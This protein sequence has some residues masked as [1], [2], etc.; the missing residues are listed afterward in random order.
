MRRILPLCAVLAAACG[1]EEPPPIAAP[2]MGPSPPVAKPRACDPELPAEACK[3][4]PG[5]HRC[6]A[7]EKAH[8]GA[9]RFA[10]VGPLYGA[11]EDITRDELVAAW[12][13]GKIAAGPL[14]KAMLEPALGKGAVDLD[15]AKE[16][17]LGDKRWAIVPA[18]ALA[19]RWKVITVGGVHPLDG[20]AAADALAV[21]L[22]APGGA[23]GTAARPVANVDRAKLTTIAMTGTTAP[24]RLTAQLMEKKGVTYPARDVAPW[25]ATSDFVHISNEV[26][27]V[28]RCDTGTGKSTMSFCAKEGYIA[29]LEAA[30][31]KIVE[32]TGNH[33]ADYGR[34]WIPHTIEMY[35]KR[36][37]LWFGGGRDQIEATAPR[38]L[39]HRGNTIAFLGCNKVHT[40]SRIITNGPD[41][42]ACDLDRMEWQ[43]RDLR[44]R[45]ALVI[46]SIQHE[47]VYRH[48]P[49]DELVEDLRRLAAAG[50]AFVMG[51]QAHCPHPWEIHRG[52]YIHYGPGNLF[53]DQGWAPL[54]DAVQDKLYILDGRLLTVG[55]QYTRI[56]EK[57]RPR[58]M[59]APERAELLGRLARTGDRITGAKPLAPLVEPADPGWRPDSFLVG[60]RQERVRVWL[61][62]P[63]DPKRTYPL[64]VDLR[65]KAPRD[66]EAITIVPRDPDASA[67]LIAKFALAKYPVDPARVTPAL[68]R[69]SK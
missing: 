10:L 11:V 66:P 23:G 14:A 7:G 17:A 38:T 33:L 37:W 13:S 58:P 65:G 21:Q 44:K 39:E 18:D 16:P 54:W 2:V 45:G 41:V 40:T 4:R 67:E 69:P 49:P 31:T 42:G 53:F 57:G 12:T 62:S 68:K 51:S 25:F 35:E 15:P 29:L 9:W 64:V 24:T 8:A 32:L 59:T 60:T 1:K 3:A 36:G 52:A 55:H 30:Q 47:E 61:P 28:P 26:S 56:E 22:C 50:A 43:I 6:A 46:V 48:T 27:F 5:L 20:E 19:P 34:S 63:L